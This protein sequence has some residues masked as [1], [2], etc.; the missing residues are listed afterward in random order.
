MMLKSTEME[1]KKEEEKIFSTLG[2][3]THRGLIKSD[4]VHL[5]IALLK[6]FEHLCYFF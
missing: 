5:Q 1:K 2:E 6:G 4:L 3:A